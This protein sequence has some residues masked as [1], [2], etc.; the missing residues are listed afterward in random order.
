MPDLACSANTLRHADLATRIRAAAGAGFTAI[1]LR[2]DD[3]RSSGLADEAVRDLLDEHS[4]RIL[5][6]EH[7]WDWAAGE[8]APEEAAMFHLADTLGFRQLNVPMFTEH[9]RAELVESFGR[10][11][12]RAADHGVLVGFEFLPY[13]SSRTLA[14][15]WDVVAAADRSGG[16]V[17]IDFW[18][19]FRSDAQAADLAAVPADRITSIQLCDVLPE[20]LPDLTTEARHHRLLPG[21]GAG[22]TGELLD[23]LR[24]HGVTAP[25]SVEVFSD[26][27]DALPPAAAAKA[28]FA[29]A[30]KTLATYGQLATAPWITSL[31]QPGTLR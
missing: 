9:T 14:Q 28:A 27:L 2:L 3:Y 31:G 29:A 18:H 16:G 4:L 24:R 11:C 25:L 12:D 21:R 7:T 26:D 13:S 6:L 23:A 10:L 17:I 20:P 8:P 30:E 5:E 15:V 22:S 1:G 19:W